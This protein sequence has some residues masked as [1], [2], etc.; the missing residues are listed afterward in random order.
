MKSETATNPNENSNTNLN[1]NQLGNDNNDNDGASQRRTYIMKR[2][3]KW[4]L[5]PVK[6]ANVWDFNEDV[7]LY[8]RVRG[9]LSNIA[10]LY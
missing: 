10:A 7:V 1:A 3:R 8:K 5:K 2:A 4:E 6:V 9:L